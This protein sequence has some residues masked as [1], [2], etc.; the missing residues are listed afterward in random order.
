MPSPFDVLG[1]DPDADEEAVE[2]A[3]RRRVKEVHPDHGGSAAEF[4]EV[5]TAYERLTSGEYE[6]RGR[7]E[8]ETRAA[9][10]E[11]ERTETVDESAS[12]DHEWTPVEATVE[13]LNFA[14]LDDHDWSA[15]DPRLFRRAAAA[16]LDESD[17]GVFVVDRGE[18]VLSAAERQGYTWPYACR[19]GACANCAVLLVSGEME[20]SIDHVLPEQMLRRG[21]RLSCIGL[22]TTPEIQ[23]LYNVKHLPDLDDLR[24]PPGPFEG[25][26]SGD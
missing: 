10:D 14:V 22:P 25:A 15:G 17:Y 2:R 12:E 21:I 24:L 9:P 7:N 8:D 5:R 13:Y 1:V 26:Q 4:R 18:T 6:G 3:Y 20:M 11:G 19:G 16:G 23:L